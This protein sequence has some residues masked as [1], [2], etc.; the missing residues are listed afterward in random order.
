MLTSLPSQI[1]KGSS[2]LWLYPVANISRPVYACTRTALWQA[3]INLVHLAAEQRHL[4]TEKT[5]SWWFN[6][7]F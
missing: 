7:N 1:P 4:Q 3:G 5:W 6:S 2:T